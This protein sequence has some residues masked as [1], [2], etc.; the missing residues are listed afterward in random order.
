MPEH[1]DFDATHHLE[2]SLEPVT[3]IRQSGAIMRMGRMMLAAGTASYRVKE[4]MHAVARS[5]GVTGHSE[6]VT[7]TEITATTHR[8]AI[9]R[10]EVSEVRVISVDADRIVRLD[11]LRRDLPTAATTD[12]IHERLNEIEQAP[13]RYPLWANAC[14]AGA[15]CAGFA[16]LNNAR[17]WE[18]LSVFVAACAGQALRRLLH[19]RR[20]NHFGTTMLAAA[21]ASGTYLAGLA[22]LGL[23]GV[24]LDNHA[25]GYISTVLFLLPGFALITGALDIAKLDLSAGVSRIVFGTAMTLAAGASVWA[26]S[27]AGPL[28]ISERTPETLSWAVQG[29]LW[30]AASA[31]GVFGF[32]MMFNS[33]W[34]LA[35]AAAAIGMLANTG[36]L[37]AVDHGVRVQAATEIACVVVGVLAAAVAHYGRWPVI[38]LSVPGVLVMIPGVT[39]HQAVVTVLAIMVGLVIAKLLTDRDWAFER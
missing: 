32:A 34:R 7:L 21:A 3:L 31:V 1:A 29:G 38:T 22:L 6:H 8:G 15:A 5:L 12:Q 4:G 23:L 11:R 10:T 16:V 28:D 19:R 25:A 30:S 36:R 35:V 26:V 13:A 37:V 9:F 20:L 17:V 39:A 18:V 2:D 14:F 24:Q 33:P 27:L